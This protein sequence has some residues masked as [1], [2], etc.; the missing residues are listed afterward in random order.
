M[1]FLRN[2]STS[3]WLHGLENKA[4]CLG[5]PVQ[6]ADHSRAVACLVR[7]R[8]GIEVFKGSFAL[9]AR[10]RAG[11]AHRV[12]YLLGSARSTSGVSQAC[13]RAPH[14]RIRPRN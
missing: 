1:I 5:A 8:S 3:F 9:N 7:R 11:I 12:I 4:E 6:I 2:G 10:R 13:L 14:V